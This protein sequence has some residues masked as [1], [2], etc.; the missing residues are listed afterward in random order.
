[1]SKMKVYTDGACQPNP[2][3]GGWA[4]IN[5][6]GEQDS[7]ACANSTNQRMELISA[8]KALESCQADEV[9][10]YSDSRYLVN[11]AEGRWKRKSNHDLFERLD[12]LVSKKSV[13]FKW[14]S[15]ESEP[16]QVEV[17][18]LAKQAAKEIKQ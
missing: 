1:M 17:D 13:K 12:A 16:L 9:C 5:E 15:R 6:A 8:I 4:W 10:I 7:G 2:G 3:A 14:I 11:C 18:K